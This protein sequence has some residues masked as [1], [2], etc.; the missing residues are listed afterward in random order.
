[1]TSAP[2]WERALRCLGDVMSWLAMSAMGFW[3][4]VDSV[5]S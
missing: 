1:M 2:E 4:V 3:V 5:A